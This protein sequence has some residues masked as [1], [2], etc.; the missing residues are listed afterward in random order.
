MA[1]P[2]LPFAPQALDPDFIE[3]WDEYWYEG[4]LWASRKSKDPRCRVGAVIVNDGVMVAS[5]FNGLARNVFDDPH[6]LND[7]TEKL[8]R[9]C[10]AEANAICNAARQ[11]VR[12]LG[13][14]IFVTKFPCLACLNAI[15]QA[16]ITR[17][18]THDDKFWNDDPA[19]GDHSRKLSMIK[20]SKVEVVAPFHPAFSTKR[21]G[22]KKSTTV[23][24]PSAPAASNDAEPAMLTAAATK[25]PRKGAKSAASRSDAP[26]LFETGAGKKPG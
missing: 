16:G 15:L 24:V 5:G 22:A 3:S 17:I 6:V 2:L 12:L 1:T 7:A 11:G 21:R 20:Q 26:G 14:T 25:K 9:I 10:H 19:D 18:Y 23:A 8:K 13:A 4:A